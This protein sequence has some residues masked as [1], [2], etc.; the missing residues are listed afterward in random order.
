MTF[1][2]SRLKKKDLAKSCMKGGLTDRTAQVGVA[3]ALQTCIREVPFSN[4]CHDI[5]LNMA[6]EVF[7]RP[8]RQIPC[9]SESEHDRGHPPFEKKKIIFCFHKI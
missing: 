6:L 9:Y 7:R 4:L 3:E 2:W 5:Y 1:V 8:S